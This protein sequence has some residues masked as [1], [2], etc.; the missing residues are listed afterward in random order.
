MEQVQENNSI[1]HSEILSSKLGKQ[2]RKRIVSTISVIGFLVSSTYATLLW[3]QY[4]M[5]L[6]SVTDL[7]YA[8]CYVLT[9]YWV[10]QNKLTL[11]SYWIVLIA[12]L[13][14]TLGSIFFVGAETGFQLYFMTLPV[15]VYFLLND[16]AGWRKIALLLYGCVCFIAGHTL[17]VETFMAPIPTE[18][19]QSIFIG[20]ALIIFII[21]VSA[22]KFFS[23]EVLNAYQQQNKLILTDQL[24]N[25]A[26]LRF[27]QQYAS[28]LLSQ[29]DRYGHPISLIY[30]DINNFKQINKE[31]G[32]ASGDRCLELVVRQVRNDIRDADILARIGGDEFVIILPETG[33]DETKCLAQR[34]NEDINSMR[35]KTDQ[36]SF[37]VSASFG[38]SACDSSNMKSIEELIT[39]ARQIT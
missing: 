9:F 20:N 34:L 11:A 2:Y 16:E 31:H 10:K 7:L 29:A 36:T 6:S 35:L 26:N 39:E 21:V 22:V 23:D 8:L 32:Q 25:I 3:T 24:T 1:Q 19:A 18:I 30:F 13:Q 17:R 37:L 12:S 38:F 4:H 33:I 28:K 14:V 15:V 27:V 5:V